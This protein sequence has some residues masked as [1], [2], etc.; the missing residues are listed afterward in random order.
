VGDLQPLSY[1]RANPVQRGLRRVGASAPGSW[2]F[3]RVLHHIDRPVHRLT[4]GRA[5]LT[6]ILTGLPVVMLTTTGA[7]SG[8]TRAVPLLGLPTADGLAVIAS[9]YGQ[10]RDPAWCHNLRS[11]PDATLT[12]AGRPSPVR[13]AEAHGEQRDRIWAAGLLVYPG[14]AVYERRATGRRIPVFVLTPV[15]DPPVT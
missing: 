12:V 5:T 3:A 6:S 13:A 4:R 9:N 8:A 14:W 7:R 1:D 2:V 11:Q 10:P 15:P